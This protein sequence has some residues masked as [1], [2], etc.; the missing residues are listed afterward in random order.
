MR[1]EFIGASNPKEFS[2][3]WN[4][5]VE[6]WRWKGEG[7]FHLPAA[8]FL[9]SLIPLLL[10]PH[11]RLD[12]S[13]RDEQRWMKSAGP[14]IDPCQECGDGEI[15]NRDEERERER[16]K[17]RRRERGRIEKERERRRSIMN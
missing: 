16:G 5:D 2:L 1:S 4:E 3:G 7:H 17:D 11:R 12:I 14:S 9:P 15:S 6:N 13:F 10:S 8:S